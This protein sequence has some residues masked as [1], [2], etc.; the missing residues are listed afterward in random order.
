MSVSVLA[1][2]LHGRSRISRSVV[3]NESAGEESGVMTHRTALNQSCRGLRAE[4]KCIPV[5]DFLRCDIPICV[6]Q[7]VV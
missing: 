6:L 1:L 7:T 5:F 4:Q 2:A 3:P